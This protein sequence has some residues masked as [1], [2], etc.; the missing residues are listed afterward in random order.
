MDLADTVSTSKVLRHTSIH[1]LESL[2]PP[3]NL[4][5]AFGGT[6]VVSPA[7]SAASDTEATVVS[8]WGEAIE[9]AKMELRAEFQSKFDQHTSAITKVGSQVVQHDIFVSKL[10]R[11]WTIRNVEDACIARMKQIMGIPKSEK[12]V[13]KAIAKK[14]ADMYTSS[15]VSVEDLLSLGDLDRENANSLFHVDLQAEDSETI[16]QIWNVAKYA[17]PAGSVERVGRLLEFA[18]GNSN[19]KL[20]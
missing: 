8:S 10:A 12:V 3:R 20:K 5:S 2:S 9:R 6:I 13:F 19:V 1:D 18:R 11:A 16:D 15:V 4:Q 7:K 17:I 14:F